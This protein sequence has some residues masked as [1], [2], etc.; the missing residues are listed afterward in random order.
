MIS[1]ILYYDILLL[2]LILCLVFFGHGLV[3]LNLSPSY[4][5]HYN[6]I[7]AVNFTCFSTQSLIIFHG[8]FDITISVFLFLFDKS[9]YLLYTILIYLFCVCISAMVFY[10]QQT[11]YIF[12]FA[13]CL[14]RL[15]WILITVFLIFE[16]LGIKKYFLIRIA[17]SFAFL[18][19]GFASLGFLGLNQG[20]IDLAMQI[21]SK[22][23]ARLFVTYTGYS[24]IIIGLF[25]LQGTLTRYFAFVGALWII[26]ILYLSF[27]NAFPDAIFRFGFLILS[28][29]VIIDKRCYT[30]KFLK[31]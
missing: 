28:I 9:K 16:L 20:H 22:E 2:R 31:K 3:S 30:T 13:E 8:F 4:I 12:G 14:R 29:Y 11:N 10:Y 6:L 24:D 25:I 7:D 15:P 26:F 18:S 5:L 23:N 27:L 21:I 19:H 1:K 17:L